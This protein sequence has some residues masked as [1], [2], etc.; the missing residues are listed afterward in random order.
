MTTSETDLEVVTVAICDGSYDA[1]IEK[2]GEYD[3][4]PYKFL[5]LT[6]K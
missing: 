4:H 1:E 5:A 2:V 6:W 3:P